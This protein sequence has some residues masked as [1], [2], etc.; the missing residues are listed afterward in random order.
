MHDAWAQY[1]ASPFSQAFFDDIISQGAPDIDTSFFLTPA[2]YPPTV[3]D[4]NHEWSRM[5]EEKQAKLEKLRRYQEEV[6]K[7][8]AELAL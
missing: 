6:R 3:S 2:P 7:L 1:S 5:A 8:E 4:E